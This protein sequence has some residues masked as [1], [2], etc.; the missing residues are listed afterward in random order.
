M[1]DSSQSTTSAQVRARD[2]DPDRI[3]RRFVDDL[4]EIQ[5]LYGRL[6]ELTRDQSRILQLGVSEELLHLAEAK[7]REM[8]RLEV[9]EERLRGA[10]ELWEG[11]Q[12]KITDQQKARVKTLMDGV[13]KVLKD[14][15]ALEEEENRRLLEK[16]EETVQE[17][18]RLDG[19]RKFQGAYAS[20]QLPK[21][22]RLLDQKE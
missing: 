16:R 7:E 9:L 18:R 21:A 12:T 5:T 2:A 22:P 11:I 4:E 14:L 1:S 8:A 6:T 20:T 17:I 3:Y 15:V 19:V 13:S 10:R